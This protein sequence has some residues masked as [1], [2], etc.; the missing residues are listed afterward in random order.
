VKLGGLETS[1]I[2]SGVEFVELQG[3]LFQVLQ[4]CIHNPHALVSCDHPTPYD[5]VDNILPHPPSLDRIES[6]RTWKS[7][8][9][10]G[11]KLSV[12]LGSFIC[13]HLYHR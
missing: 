1:G 6:S 4:D 10:E 3:V 8:H 9:I 7:D 12:H 2:Q 11:M 13:G 5:I